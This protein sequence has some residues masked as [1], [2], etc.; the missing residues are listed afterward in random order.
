M[1]ARWG[2][3]ARLSTCTHPEG[4]C[5]EPAQPCGCCHLSSVWC[6]GLTAIQTPC[7]T[8]QLQECQCPSSRRQLVPLAWQKGTRGQWQRGH[9]GRSC[10]GSPAPQHWEC[11]GGCTWQAL[12]PHRDLQCYCTSAWKET[13]LH[14]GSPFCLGSVFIYNVS[15]S[16]FKMLLLLKDGNLQLGLFNDNYYHR[17]WRQRGKKSLPLLWLHQMTP[18][19]LCY[20][21]RKRKK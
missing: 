14:I 8:K 7:R 2:G 21:S 4:S 19:F 5:D 15:W 17:S 10:H 6:S 3:M 1:M 12:P 20:S 18:F 11:P 16:I 9:V 13:S